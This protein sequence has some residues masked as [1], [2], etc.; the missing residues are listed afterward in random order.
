MKWGKHILE[1]YIL[2]LL[3]GN[4]DPLTLSS[5]RVHNTRIVDSHASSGPDSLSPPNIFLS[6]FIRE[7]IILIEKKI[8]RDNLLRKETLIFENRKKHFC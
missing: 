5:N 1:S 6:S 7:I 4:W 2:L 8:V 3:S